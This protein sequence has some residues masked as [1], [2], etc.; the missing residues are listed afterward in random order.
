M[1]KIHEVTP[2]FQ[3]KNVQA[4]VDFYRDKLGFRARYQ[5]GDDMAIVERD[6]TDIILTRADDDSWRTR[7]NFSQR[8]VASGA[9]S[10]LPGTGSCRIRV[11]GVDELYTSYQPQGII[12]RNGTLR[13]QPWGVRDFSIGDLDGNAVAFFERIGPTQQ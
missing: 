5:S 3:V 9:E 10:F 6:G 7:A 11:D 8:P 2:V 12:H 1:V 4:S 13:N